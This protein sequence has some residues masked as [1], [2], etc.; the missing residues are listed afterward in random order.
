MPMTP[1]GTAYA[2]NAI[3]GIFSTLAQA[4]LLEKKA[5]LDAGLRAAQTYQSTQAGRLN[6]AKAGNEQFTLDNRRAVPDTIAPDAT[7]QELANYLFRQAGAGNVKDFAS[8]MGELQTQNFRTQAAANINNVD[9]MNSFNTLAKP[10]AT[11]EPFANVG[12]T[13]R[14]VNKATGL[15]K[16]IDS[17]LATGY[18]SEVAS[19][20]NENNAQASNAYASAGRNQAATSKINLEVD[21]IKAGG[22]GKPL[23]A[24]QLR[25]N[26]AVQEARDI[27]AGMTQDEVNALLANNPSMMTAEQQNLYRAYQ[28]ANK[29]M[30]GEADVPA[31]ASKPAAP[32][33][34]QPGFL[35]QLWNEFTAPDE[36][37]AAKS[38]AA[39][40]ASNSM[41]TL[42]DQ[43]Q[44]SADAIRAA[45]KAGKITRDEAKKQ[46]QAIGF[47]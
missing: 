40:S 16:I 39:P 2:Q 34:E 44:Q 12:N 37:P 3:R 45:Y 31:I 13:G 7:T 10:G 38:A 43:T 33:V 9:R 22:P 4:P 27:L 20:R 41:A 15:G 8:G 6:E 11:Y 19:R 21:R 5:E 14:A 28:R 36:R 35:R 17:A 29:P 30:Y 32:K 42:P 1:N 23:T 24:A 46:L 25:E 47:Q 26:A 18:D